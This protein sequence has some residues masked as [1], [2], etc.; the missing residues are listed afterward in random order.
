MWL[1]VTPLIQLAE[2]IEKEEPQIAKVTHAFAKYVLQSRPMLP[3]EDDEDEVWWL[4][5]PSFW[6][7]EAMAE[8]EVVP[9]C[10][11]HPGG[12]ID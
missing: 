7:I 8:V 10:P 3:K 5:R 2:R 1:A 11:A 4:P 12:W 6:P 9:W